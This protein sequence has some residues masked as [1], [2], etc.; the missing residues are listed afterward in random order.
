MLRKGFARITALAAIALLSI[1][2]F[3]GDEC[4]A[5][6]NG[7]YSEDRSDPD[8]GTHDWIAERALA[9]VTA[10]K[11]F[12][13]STYH[14]S[15]LLGTE[16]PDN[17][18]MIGDTWNHHV[19][20]EPPS[21]LV[22]DNSAR[23][24]LDSYSIAK[25]L[26]ADGNFEL[27]AYYTGAM[28]HYISDVGVFGHTM[29]SGTVWGAEE[30]HSDYEAEVGKRIFSLG[31]TPSMT[32]SPTDPYSATLELAR[33]V[34]FGEGGIKSNIWMDDNYDWSDSAFVSSADQS[35]F[36]SVFYV[37]CSIQYL[38]QQ[39]SPSD[40]SGDDGTAD[41]DSPDD[42]AQGPDSPNGVGSYLI[43]VAGVVLASVVAAITYLTRRLLR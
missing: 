20:Y 10:D 24:A 16:A 7:G 26:M 6:G 40:Q 36:A 8:Y 1:S 2:A 27:A 5:W 37:A 13:A 12:L 35:L 34:T 22:E 3:A 32:L 23:R 38:L 18:D 31:P 28:T 30:H 41:N 43:L 39:P 15:F 21:Q 17:P 42:G 29:G 9:L 11:T 25:D 4:A 33:K 19:Y 14:V